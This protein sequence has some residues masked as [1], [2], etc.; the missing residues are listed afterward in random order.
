MLAI[1]GERL[2]GV[3]LHLGDFRSFELGHRYD[4]VTC[5]FSSITYAHGAG[6]LTQTIGRL[7]EHLEPGGVLAVEPFFAPEQV[8]GGHVQMLCVDE[9]DLKITRMST[10]EVHD[11]T[12]RIEFHYLVGQAGEIEHLLE[13]HELS[14]FR[15]ED[16]TSA[17]GAAGLKV[18]YD[19]EGLMGRGLYL[20]VKPD[21]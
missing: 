5:L 9:P 4:V 3:S 15:H 6:E 1:A 7:A 11:G 16:Y 2:P 13:P 10:L 8:S 12:A 14:L 20:G 18:E 17:F 21:P 19:P